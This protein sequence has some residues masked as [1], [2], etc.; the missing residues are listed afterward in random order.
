MSLLDLFK[1]DEQRRKLSHL[2]NLVAVAF[3]DGKLD[4]R[5]TAMLATIMS[6]HGLNSSELKRCLND[7]KGIKFVPPKD[8]YTKLC[9]LQDMVLLMMCD[10]HIDEKE[11]IIWKATAI[12]LGYKKE[13]IDALILDTIKDMRQRMKE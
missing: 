6:H 10:G 12:G 8:D 4:N 2:R 5:E 3:A 11:M 9:Y 1:S 7:P 13:V